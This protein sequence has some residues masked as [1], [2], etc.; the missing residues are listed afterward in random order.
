MAG[1]LT[2][3]WLSISESGSFEWEAALPEDHGMSSV[4]LDQLKDDLA[5]RGTKAFLVIR[6]DRIVYEWYADGHSRTKKHYTASMAKALVGGVSLAVAIN[7]GLISLDD[8]A[9]RYVPEW[10]SHPEKSQIT[11]RQLGSH[12]SGIQDAWVNEEAAV[13]VDQGNFSGWEG[14]FWR[15]RSRQRSAGDDAFTLARDSA[16]LLFPPGSDYHYSNPGIGMLTY[17]VTASLGKSPVKDVRT[18][19]RDR[20]MRPIGIP[21]DEWSCGYGKT[22]KVEGLPLVASWGG[23]SYSANATAR[24]ARLMLRGGKWRGKQLLDADAVK[25]TVTDAGTPNNGGMGWWTNSNGDFGKAPRSSFSGQGAGHQVVLVV[26]NL[27]LICVRNGSALSSSVDYRTA[28]RQFLFDP[29]I[30]SVTSPLLL[31]QSDTPPYPPSPVIKGIDW[32]PEEEIL[33][34]ASG[35]DNWPLTWADDDRLYTAYGDGRGFE[36]FVPRKLSLGFA[37]IVGPPEAFQGSN[38][39]SATGED[40]GDGAEGRKASGILMVDGVLYLWVRNAGNSQLGLSSDYARTWT[41]ADWRFSVSFGYPTFLNFGKDYEGARDG[42]AYVYS[43]DS[44]SAY[45]A[46]DRMVLA[47]VPSS[48]IR[49]REAYEFFK[50]VDNRGNPLWTEGVDERGTVFSHPG[51]CY[52]SG[53][54]YNQNLQRY[55]WCQI[56]PQSEDSRG[57]RFQGGFGIYDAPEPWG[58]WSTVFYTREWDVGPGETSSLP[59]KWMSDD[60]QTIHLVF[61]GDDHFAV[62]RAKLTLDSDD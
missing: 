15:W 9:S 35:S 19:L 36:P 58:P 59:T 50:G 42:F 46:S 37:S 11:I 4:K 48:R 14:D 52:R 61:S 24:L 44:D 54:T 1:F 8:E 51:H 62:R 2:L 20:V 33:R 23:G 32:A 49:D 39:R 38:I 34:K 25:Q 26:P 18:L 16:P 7:D 43:H 56:H 17:A 47:R 45:V 6:N 5:T 57:P 60:G 31:S 21:D 55:L 3:N 12:T 29:L 40:L 28:I 30:N 22:E 10:R 13:G 27:D 53:I 41:W